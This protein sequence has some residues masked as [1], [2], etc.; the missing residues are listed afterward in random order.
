MEVVVELTQGHHA[1]LAAIALDAKNLEDIH[2]ILLFVRGLILDRAHLL[3]ET[4]D[5]SKQA[6]ARGAL[7]VGVHG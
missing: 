4:V 5:V 3:E 7:D 2:E 1:S 6:S